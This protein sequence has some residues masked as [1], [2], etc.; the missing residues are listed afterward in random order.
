MQHEF[1]KIKGK[2]LYAWLINLK[3]NDYAKN[4]YIVIKIKIQL[5]STVGQLHIQSARDKL[6]WFNLLCLLAWPHTGGGLNV[7]V[8][9]P[10]CHRWVFL[11]AS[12]TKCY[13]N[14]FFPLSNVQYCREPLW[15]VTCSTSELQP[16]QRWNIFR[17]NHQRVF[18]IWSHHKCP[19]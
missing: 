7:M 6:Q 5:N 9:L 3:A 13:R 4:K 17:I 12:K 8:T 11:H 16:L 18:S 19:S 15:E 2:L 14:I 1:R 10:S